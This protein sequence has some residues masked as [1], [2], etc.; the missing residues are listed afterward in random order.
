MS[1]FFYWVNLFFP[2]FDFQQD[3]EVVKQSMSALIAVFGGFGIV[4]G[5]IVALLNLFP[6]VDELL[7]VW[8]VTSLLFVMGGGLL[9][10]LK[11]F[12]QHFFNGFSV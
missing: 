2:R 3:V 9:W 1:I 11:R 5:V 12:V 7:A 6:L 8:F 4:A 10:L